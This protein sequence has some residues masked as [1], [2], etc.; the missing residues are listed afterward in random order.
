MKRNSGQP[1][2]ETQLEKLRSL[3]DAGLTVQ[4]IAKTLERSEEGVRGRAARE[5]WFAVRAPR[6]NLSGAAPGI[7]VARC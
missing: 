1:W 7:A 2:T 3:I 5:G 4:Q 6:V